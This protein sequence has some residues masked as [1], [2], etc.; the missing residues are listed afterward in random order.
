M[1]AIYECV[2][3][4]DVHQATV[5]ACRRRLIGQGQVEVEV[6][7]FG[8]STQSL[9]ALSEW[10]SEWG[11]THVAME[12]TGVLWQP[13][14]N[15]LEGTFQWVLVN[16]QHLKKVP[17][18][19][20]DVS[21]AEWIAQ[22]VQCGLLRGSFVP[23]EQVRQWR[24]LTRQRM[25]LLDSHTAVVNRIH[26]VLE[27]ANI[28]V[29]SV[30]SDV[31]GVSG[32]AMLRAMIEGESDAAKL[33]Q[34]AGGRLRQKHVQ[35]V[36]SL[37]GRLSE[38]Q[39]WLLA[40]LLHQVEFVEQEI[41]AYDAR[42]REL[43][44][45]FEAALERL[46]TIDGVGRRTAENLLAEVGPEMG[47]FASSDDLTSWAGICP[48]NHESAGNRHSGRTPGDNKWLRRVLVEA[49]WA[50]IKTKDSY[51]GAQYR[52]LAARRGKKRAIVAVGRTILV[53][54]YYIL[55]EEMEYQDL[56]GDYFDRLNEEKTKKQL[57]KRLEKLGYQV[58]LRVA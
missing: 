8:T 38:H 22:C 1:E 40:R 54:A 3:G 44:R 55:K 33:A 56:G 9:R 2:G 17:G 37:E 23:P 12:S 6:Q 20:T 36:D 16:T 19:K 39:R 21:D 11:V 10:L 25:K 26:Q 31:M 7:E 5:M 4:L 42:V 13:V 49:A 46:E 47:Q 30:A 15:V 24:D 45:P 34:L 14:W 57:V 52:R 53:A 48:G 28:K 50:G 41:A 18:R 43:M 35:L 51:L 29:S 27:Q 32:R 58:A